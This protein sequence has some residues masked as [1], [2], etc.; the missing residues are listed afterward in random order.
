MGCFVTEMGQKMALVGQ[1][2]GDLGQFI[3]LPGKEMLLLVLEN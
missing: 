3:M 2:I 1:K